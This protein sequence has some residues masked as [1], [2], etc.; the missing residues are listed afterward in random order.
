MKGTFAT[1]AIVAAMI[2]G[3]TALAGADPPTGTVTTY[4]LTPTP[5]S[6]ANIVAGPDHDV[7][8]VQPN[9]DAD[10]IGT[11]MASGMVGE[12]PVTGPS[13]DPDDLTASFDL[14]LNA[15]ANGDSVPPTSIASGPPASG[16][17][18]F[19]EALGDF[20]GL[21]EISTAGTITQTLRLPFDNPTVR[22]GTDAAGDVWIPDRANG[23][24]VE[25][26]YP[27]TS[28][29]ATITL[30]TGAEPQSITAGPD[31]TTMWVT[32][33][34]IDSVASITSAGVVTQYLLPVADTT[35]GNIVLG[36]DGNL[37][38]GVV[39]T[40]VVEAAVVD[41]AWL[42]Q[43]TPGGTPNAF[44]LPM[45]SNANP[46]VL[47]AGPDGRLWMAD[48]PAGTGDLTAMTTAGVFSDY[49]GILP[50]G[51]E[52]SSIVADPSG[53]DAV[54]MTDETANTVDQVALQPPTPPPTTTTTTTSSTTTSTS[55][56]TSNAPLPPTSNAPLPP[57]LAATLDPAS[58]VSKSGATLSGSIA[59]PAGSPPTSVTYHFDYGTTTAYGSS[60]TPGT[61]TATPAGASA[62]A[63]LSGLTP[64][65]TYHYR[66]VASDCA[67]SSCQV[68]SS[69][70]SFTTG[71]TL[72]PQVNTSVGA[73]PTTGTILIKL[74]GRH[75]YERLAVGELIPVGSIIDARHGTIL[76]KSSLGH[77][78][79]AS[80]LFSGGIF[81]VTQPHGS[82]FTDLRLESS[83]AACGSKQLKAP[84]ARAAAAKKKKAKAK[85]KRS[86]KVVNQV[87]GNAHGQF[88]TQGQYATA[89]DEGTAWRT[90]DRCDGT[91]IAV[92]A[93]R[94]VVTNVRT[95]RHFTLTAGQHHLIAG[96]P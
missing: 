25:V 84:F 23:S 10:E 92:S 27:Y 13:A 89:A 45:T 28:E 43:I 29:S 7:W 71:S 6:P 54:W 14:S 70:Q 69:D 11:V 44:P 56:T 58:D 32:E 9:A 30:P 20:S 73:A 5:S 94:V 66:L 64:Y 53:G 80:G 93:G 50:A 33:P 91:Q 55:T 17:L 38:V 72:A 37:W 90:S 74:P 52:I 67:I 85:A 4:A 39:E 48:G 63:S 40:A 76:I 18:F 96:S 1:A 62:S 22:I 35:M 8:F 2:W 16:L 31:G 51:D 24:V 78:E 19:I 47:A 65:T 26:D 49:P 86:H 46:D 75:K 15:A 59:E 87:F 61:T 36:S 68:E 41:P 12:F 21:A 77:G 95:H 42:V 60:T 88:A 34:G 83:F 3:W 79:V 57:I 82:S 81:E